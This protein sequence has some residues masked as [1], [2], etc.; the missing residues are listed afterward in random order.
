MGRILHFLLLFVCFQ[1][2]S[3]I[4]SSLNAVSVVYYRYQFVVFISLTTFRI[5]KFFMSKKW[6]IVPRYWGTMGHWVGHTKYTET[7]WIL[8]HLIFIYLIVQINKSLLLGLQQNSCFSCVQFVPL[9]ITDEGKI[10]RT[11]LCSKVPLSL[12]HV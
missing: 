7:L 12:L 1:V 8:L 10:K 11:S 9:R 6:P 4:I 2:T 5:V 3:S